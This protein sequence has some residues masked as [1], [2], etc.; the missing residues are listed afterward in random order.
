M[1]KNRMHFVTAAMYGHQGGGMEELQ[2][3]VMRFMAILAFCLVAIFALVQSIPLSPAQLNT[4]PEIVETDSGP[5]T[6]DTLPLVAP[7]PGS[8]EEKASPLHSGPV[9]SQED[10]AAPKPK[11]T[12]K[13]MT[14]PQP[15]RVVATP[16]PMTVT[17]FAYRGPVPSKAT[18]PDPV[19][20]TRSL[21]TV[22]VPVEQKPAPEQSPEPVAEP[23]PRQ[24]PEP[25]IG[26]SLKFASAAALRELVANNQVSFFALTK[27]DSWRLGMRGGELVFRSASRPRQMHEMLPS[28]VPPEVINAL[29]R[30]GVTASRDSLRWGVVLTE[31]TSQQLQQILR[32]HDGGSLTIM[33]NGTVKL[34]P[35]GGNRGSRGGPA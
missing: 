10:V 21:P 1:H 14:V 26:F 7:D 20:V 17:R 23:P 29:G 27:S 9:F 4:P 31:R 22:D 25:Q 32:S 3:D 34:E 16:D 28:T 35:A 2:T 5:E 15:E 13:E 24:Q 6:P 30:T 33:N 11:P 19:S 12:P 8:L 18:T